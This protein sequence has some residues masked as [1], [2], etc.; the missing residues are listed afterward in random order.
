MLTKTFF[1]MK[2]LGKQYFDQEIGTPCLDWILLLITLTCIK[3]ALDSLSIGPNTTRDI[4]L[5]IIKL[6]MHYWG[7]F[8][9]EGIWKNI[10]GYKFKI[11]IG[12]SGGVCCRK[13]SY[14]HHE[15]AIILKYIKV[16]LNNGWIRECN[17]GPYGAP[18]VLAPKQHQEDVTDI[19]DFI[20]CMCVSYR[21]LNKIII[22]F[23]Y[24]IGRCDGAV[25]VLG[26]GAGILYLISIDCAQG[27]YQI[28]V[29]YADQEKLAF[30]GP[31]GK[32]YT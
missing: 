7:V 4:R 3:K 25:K 32:K 6:T 22:P 2:V 13:L 19:K 9:P 24:P 29:W 10:L 23:E 31:D 14:C 30:F 27:Y 21:A 26:D 18:I 5:Q 1:Y 20:W 16:L 15:G 12:T 8:A 28:R 17:T 11:D